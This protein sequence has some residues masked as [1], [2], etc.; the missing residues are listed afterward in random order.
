[1]QSITNK[2]VFPVL[3]ADEAKEL[4]VLG[5]RLMAEKV[6]FNRGEAQVTVPLLLNFLHEH[7]KPAPWIYTFDF[8]VDAPRALQESNDPRLKAVTDL[9]ERASRQP[10][11]LH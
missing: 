5:H 2:I 1:M 11:T 4:I 7:T 3:G 9:V 10:T 6:K 8:S